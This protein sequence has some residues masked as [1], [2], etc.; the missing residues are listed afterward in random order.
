MVTDLERVIDFQA[1]SL[2]KSKKEFT[3]L[4]SLEMYHHKHQID[5]LRPAMEVF[6]RRKTIPLYWSSS[7]FFPTYLE[8]WVRLRLRPFTYPRIYWP[9]RRGI[10]TRN[11]LEWW[12]LSSKAN[13]PW[14][15]RNLVLG[16]MFL[17]NSWDFFWAMICYGQQKKLFRELRRRKTKTK[18]NFMRVFKRRHASVDMY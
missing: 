9:V 11:N 18:R 14:G 2:R 7:Q 3:R 17:T 6:N 16:H 15:V 10:C 12:N 4:E 5:G 13:Q 1:Y 8:F